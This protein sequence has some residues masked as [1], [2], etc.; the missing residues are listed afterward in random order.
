MIRPNPMENQ[1]MIF[2]PYLIHGCAIN[3]NE[4]ITRMSLEVRFIRNDENGKKQESD[5]NEFLKIRNWR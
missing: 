2:S 4:D 5:F 3:N 1:L